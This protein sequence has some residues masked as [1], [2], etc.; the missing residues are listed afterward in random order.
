MKLTIKQLKH[1]DISDSKLFDLLNYIS[2]FTLMLK[3]KG[4]DKE[5]VIVIS[6]RYMI[7]VIKSYNSLNR[8]NF[9]I[10]NGKTAIAMSIIEFDRCA[11]TNYFEE[12]K[13]DY[14]SNFKLFWRSP[15]ANVN[16]QYGRLGA[17]MG[18]FT[19]MEK[20]KEEFISVRDFQFVPHLLQSIKLEKNGMAFFEDIA[21]IQP[22]LGLGNG[23]VG[24]MLTI[25]Y[26][27]ALTGNLTFK[28]IVYNLDIYQQQGWS[29]KFNNWADYNKDIKDV[30]THWRHIKE[31]NNGNFNFFRETGND[32][33]YWYGAEG[34][35]SVYLVLYHLFKDAN[36]LQKAI[37]GLNNLINKI[38]YKLDNKQLFILFSEAWRITKN[39][40]FK[41]VSDKI[42]ISLYNCQFF[43]SYNICLLINKSNISQ[44][45]TGYLM[46]QNKIEFL[47]KKFKNVS[48]KIINIKLLYISLLFK[49]FPKS[50]WSWSNNTNNVPENFPISF[51]DNEQHLL[52]I[53]KIIKIFKAEIKSSSNNKA[54]LNEA[55]QIDIKSH[56]LIQ[57][58]SNQA[59]I[60][61]E[62][63]SLLTSKET[64]LCL[65]E[66]SFPNQK[67]ILNSRLDASI[68]NYD[69]NDVIP[70]NSFPPL[71]IGT[72]YFLLFRTS[73]GVDEDIMS[74]YEFLILQQFL[75]KTFVYKA[76]E[77]YLEDINI[78]GDDYSVAYFR[79]LEIIRKLIFKTYLI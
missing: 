68:S 32:Y 73:L 41:L 64:L 20:Q 5:E 63:L 10:E 6:N 17:L 29:D 14:K 67:L 44:I 55:L 22:A 42:L 26:L 19:C 69:W 59:L 50:L 74:P 7:N 71:K 24:C 65:D 21:N 57:R 75:Q 58:F 8:L 35:I 47:T 51:D 9:S 33:S 48:Q 3:E 52:I 70:R 23:N 45:E 53:Q 56:R 25:G 16:Y 13:E 36:F 60:R 66:Q 27:Y 61:A 30:D 54:I 72:K 49:I 11:G 2:L 4:Y 37:F 78:S 46:G 40:E 79:V 31:F 28:S 1:F 76:V 12:I 43:V 39:E 38:N 18:L 77:A 34:I 62:E 15:N